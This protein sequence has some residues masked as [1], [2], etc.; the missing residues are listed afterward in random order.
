SFRKDREGFRGG[1]RDASGGEA[2]HKGGSF[3][4]GRE[5]FG[6]GRRDASG[7]EAG[8]KGGSF[9]KDR[10]GFRG[11][12][13]D[14]S[15]GEAGDKR[16]SFR[17][18]REG[19]R[20][21]RRDASTTP[22]KGFGGDRKKPAVDG[23]RS[24]RSGPRD[25]RPARPA[26][27]TGERDDLRIAKVISRAGLCSRR[28]AERWIAEGRVKVNG[29]TLETPAFTVK[30]DDKVLVDDQPLPDAREITLWRYH[31][32]KGR[33][34]THKDPEGR[35]TVFEALP[36]WM[37]RVISVGRLDFNT[38]GLLLLTTSGALARHLELPATGLLRRYRVRA[39]GT[40]TQQQLDALKDGV[41]IEGVV[42]GPVEATLNDSGGS[43]L[44]LTVGLREGK[45][46]EVRRILQHL[47]LEVGR[48]IRVSYG[49]FQLREL[50]PGDVEQVKR[51][52]LAEQLGPKVA[53]D[54]GLDSEDED[55]GSERRGP[56]R[57][58]GEPAASRT[59]EADKASARSSRNKLAAPRAAVDRYKEESKSRLVR[60]GGRWVRKNVK[61]DA[62]VVAPDDQKRRGRDRPVQ[63]ARP[64][65]SRPRRDGPG[66]KKRQ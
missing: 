29:K 66:G 54:L 38:E 24:E 42:Y 32:P 11:G 18:D 5:G 8:D 55:P 9:R 40:V 3:R 21:E 22:R 59:T 57:R 58:S 4:K 56:V 37:G 49:P 45:N 26:P 25:A 36:P 6:G 15:G 31:K 10:E 12:R 2:G 34:T 63:D 30:A 28:D 39:R 46:R 50:K 62:A 1:R 52:V 53:A 61:A 33:V 17:K 47:G 65:N 23:R 60:R 43:N 19:F 51:R 27:S 35:P 48:L 13:R 64:K 16:G 14:A 20:G 7:G 41:E 44:W